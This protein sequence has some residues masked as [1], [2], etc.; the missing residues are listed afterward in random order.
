MF[1]VSVWV[2]LSLCVFYISLLFFRCI[3]SG[4]FCVS[5][6]WYINWQLVRRQFRDVPCDH[7]TMPEF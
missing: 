3:F 6:Y 7:G 4:G 5:I 2:C 1:Y